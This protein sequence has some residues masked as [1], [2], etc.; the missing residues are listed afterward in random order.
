MRKIGLVCLLISSLCVALAGAAA[1]VRIM[2]L[3]DSLTSGYTVPTYLSGYRERLVTLLTTAGYNVD[4]VG[5]Q[6]D[7]S[8]PALPSPNQDHEGHPGWRIDQ[9]DANIEA[10]LGAINDPDVILLL[11]GTNDFYQNY[12]WSGATARL[13]NLVTKISTLRPYAKILLANLPLQTT[14]QNPGQA[15]AQSTF[16]ASI[17]GIVSGQVALGRQVYFVNM[18][19]SLIASDLSSDGVHPNQTGYNKMAATWSTAITGVISPEG[20]TNPPAITRIEPQVDLTHVA[21]TFSKPV[22]DAS[23][24]LANFSLSGGVVISNAVL[25][26]AT[27]RTITL[28]TSPRTLGLVYTLSVSG[29]RDRTPQQTLIAPG[30]TVSFHMD[31]VTNGSFESNFTGWT[32]TG[33]AFIESEAAASYTATDGVKLASFN[34]NSTSDVPVTGVISQAFATTAGTTYT[35]AFDMGVIG[36]VNAEQRFQVTVEGAGNLLTQTAAKTKVTGSTAQWT[37]KSYTFMANSAVATLTFRDISAVTT[38]IDALLDNV[39]VTALPS[40]GPP[41]AVGDAATIHPGQKI[42][43]AVL[44]NDSGAIDPTTVQVV[45]PPATGTA[46]VQPSGEILYTHPGASTAPVSFS[47][48]F[49]G[50]NGLSPLASVNITISAALRIPNNTLNV[51]AAPPATAVQVVPAY[52]GVTFT[53]PLCFVSPPGD[54]KRLFVCEMDGRIKVIPDVTAANPTSS[55]VLNL[56]Q[57]ITTPPRT[58]AEVWPPMPGGEEAGL[59]GMAFHPNYAT[60]GYFYVSYMTVKSSDSSVFYQRLSRFTIPPAQIGQPAPV[61]DPSSERILIEQRDRNYGHNGGAMHFAA[62]GYLYWAIGDEGNQFNLQTNAQRIDMNFFSAMLRIDVDKK[63]GNIEP[64]AHPNPA[65]AAGGFNSVNAIPRDEIPAGSGNFFARYSIPIDNTF[66]A[67]SK[68]GTWNGV[69]N[70]SA[71]STANL[72]YVRSEFWAVGLRSPWRFSID[73]PTGE[74]WVGD[75]GQDTYEEL[76]TITKGGN[77][78]WPFRDGAHPGPRT[79][80]PGFTS[81]DPL[82]EYLHTTVSGGDSNF[83]GNCIVGGLV[84]RGTR[85]ASLTGAYIFGDHI[86]GHIWAL[87]RPGGVPTVQRIAGQTGMTTFGTDPS[88]GDVLVSDYFGGRIMRIVTATPGTGF[89]ATLSATRLF[90]DLTDLSPAPGVLPYAPNLPFWSDHAVKRRWFTIPDSTSKMTWSR[91]GAWT[92]PSGQIW[93]KHFDLETERGNPAS[94]K[95]RLETRLLVKNPSGVYGVSY[96][97]NEAGTDATLVEDGG[98]EVPVNITVN[99]APYTQRWQFPSRSQCNSCHSPQAGHALSFNTRQL[100]LDSTI[101]GFA[102]NQIDLLKNEGY[103]SNTPESSSVL[104]RHYRA[105]ETAFSLE[106]R[107]RSYLAVN[108]SYCHAGVA[109]TA[110][111]SWDGR[112]ELTLAQTGLINGPTTLAGPDFKLIAPADTVHSVVLQRMAV[113]GGFTRMPPLG[114][115]ETDPVNIALVTDWINQLPPNS[116][117]APVAVADAYPVTQ[118]TALVVPP[119]GVLANDTDAQSNPLTAVM[120]TNPSHGSLNLNSNGGFTYT[121]AANYTGADSFTYHANDGSLS[122]NIVSVNITVNAPVPVGLV[123]GSFE[124]NFSGWT[125]TGNVFIESA[126]SP[127]TATNGVKLASFNGN[128]TIDVPVSGVLSQTFATSPGTPYTL[129]F[130]MGVIGSVN[131]EQRFQV[132]VDG[133]GNLLTQTAAKTKVAGS[134]AQWTAMSY[135]FVANSTTATLTFRDISTVTTNIDALLDNIRIT[136]NT[137]TPPTITN[138]TDKSTDE[139][140]ATSAIAFTVGDPETAAASLIVSRASSNI[141]LVPLANV[142]LGGSGASRTVT[143][144]P[145]ANQSGTTTITLTVSDGTLTASDTFVLTVNEVFA[146]D[147]TDWLADYNLVGGAPDSDNDSIHNA[148]EYVI[149]GNPVTEMNLNLLPTCTL[150]DSLPGGN[151]EDP[152]YVRFTYRRT[153]RAKNN[154]SA[155][156]AVEWATALVGLWTNVNATANIVTEITDDDFAVGV[157]RV[158][159]YLP[160]SLAVEG[161]FFTRLGVTITPP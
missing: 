72:P 16:N 154:P 70:G 31:A 29:V 38:N 18:N 73:A 74:M 21:V 146:D 116:N 114:S 45:S 125:V 64:N 58:P 86:S 26:S 75:V 91:D 8:N 50:A 62:D 111:A 76:H 109:G 112:P 137:N 20:T 92:F 65:A 107:V 159:V 126:T 15:T 55:L 39:R 79:P 143:I 152:D 35:L 105:G 149:G 98:E 123:N 2:P 100:N 122:S 88:N 22:A 110:P 133:A 37:P 78:G 132:T 151:P 145:A 57:V 32:V 47:Y 150:V 138:V 51:P 148:V 42:L 71:I 30:S 41:L 155:S 99:G 67:I 97:W 83:K 24:S 95:K 7:T 129:A 96:R 136:A 11:I 34:G 23:T 161:K 10:W 156:I 131:A 127:Y 135:T 104:P 89:P 27:K 147:F 140:T 44:A 80:P 128:S 94:P 139:D 1:P 118:N 84:Y 90:A 5:T 120:D 40:S 157:D 52:P 46:T 60:N 142:V 77:Y 54:T 130:D 117:T 93:V 124:S 101:S 119:A 56:P 69:F 28:T 43:L 141:S 6:L 25:D 158:N 115:T 48:R 59:L 12:S 113:T 33:N 85:F 160:R 153:D 66:V 63:P 49:S 134:T 61:A 4:Y 36:S 106:E 87:T 144:T 9:I 53:E 13:D 108:C 19:S 121:P 68:G 81:T 82:Y 14:Y 102:G 3:G 103:F 17:S